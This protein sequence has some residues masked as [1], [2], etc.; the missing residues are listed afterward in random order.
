MFKFSDNVQRIAPSATMAISARAAAM[1]AAGDDVIALAAGEPDFATP[2]HIVDAAKAALDE[3]FTKYTPASGTPQL[4]AAWA[5]KIGRERGITYDPRQLI[6][7]AGGKQA[8]FNAIYALAGPGDEV[9]VP[10]PYWVSYSEQ[11]KAVGATLVVIQTT[12]KDHFKLTVDALRHAITDRTSLLI[13][14]SPSNPTGSVYTRAELEGLAQLLVEYQV[15]VLSDEVYDA[16][17]YGEPFTSIASLG[18]EIYDLTVVVCA[19]SKTYAMT[20]WR[21]GCAAGPTDVISACGR[22]QSHSTVAPTRSRSERP[23]PPSAAINPPS[24]RCAWRLTSAARPCTIGLAACLASPA[25]SPPGRST[26]F[27]MSQPAMGSVT[28]IRKSEA[29][30]ISAACCSSTR[31]W[32]SCPALSLA[33]TITFG[34]LMPPAWSKSKKPSIAW[35]ALLG[36]STESPG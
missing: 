18:K 13:L 36:E 4:R 6:V 12:A 7:T 25:S 22:L 31:R 29:Q 15:P 11:V 1:K 9:I 30:W 8:V 10:A 2:Q 33:M 5:D 3:G 17:V 14:C 27:L 19:V 20:G 16:L 23:W 35:S 34:S 24:K 32:R 28:M 21:I 26:P